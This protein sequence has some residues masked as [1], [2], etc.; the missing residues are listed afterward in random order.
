MDIKELSIVSIA[1]S[2]ISVA[3]AILVQA[4]LTRRKQKKRFDSQTQTVHTFVRP[5]AFKWNPPKTVPV[6][7]WKFSWGT[8]EVWRFKT[9]DNPFY[10]RPILTAGQIRPLQGTPEGQDF[11]RIVN[12]VGAENLTEGPPAN[13]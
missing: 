8:P 10:D 4:G 12:R 13:A 11:D 7:K 2:V 3:V 1:V 6:A 9:E 5:L